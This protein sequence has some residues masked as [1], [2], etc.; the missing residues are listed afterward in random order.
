[1]L[2]QSFSATASA[3]RKSSR[4]RLAEIKGLPT[5]ASLT[6]CNASSHVLELFGRSGLRGKEAEF[7]SVSVAEEPIAAAKMMPH[8][9]IFI[10]YIARRVRFNVLKTSIFPLSPFYQGIK[11]RQVNRK[12]YD[13]DERS[14]GAGI[15]A[16]LVSGTPNVVDLMLFH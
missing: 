15:S 1:L 6:R 4:F 5:P 7:A 10:R 11:F 2:V 9:F 14:Q 13:V 16:L 12:A 3:S 8:T